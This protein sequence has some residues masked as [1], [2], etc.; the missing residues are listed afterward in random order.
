ML[1]FGVLFSI[2]LIASLALYAGTQAKTQKKMGAGL[3]TGVML[4]TIIGGA[5]TVGTAQLAFTYG[6]CAWWFTIGCGIATLILAFIFVGPF[7][8]GNGKT[9]IG[10]I[11]SEYGQHVGVTASVL[12]S[13]G[14][15]INV[16]S[17]LIAATSVIAVV[18]PQ[19]N[20]TVSLI[21]SALLMI[22]YVVF[23]G[24]RGAGIVGLLK[25]T[26][27]C[28]SMLSCG[29]I[30]LYLCDGL[31]GFISM[32]KTIETP[33]GEQYL[34][35]F[36]RGLSTDLGA[37]FSLLVGI[38]TTQ[39]YCQAITTADSNQSARRGIILSSLLIPIIGAGGVLVGLYMRAHYPE[40]LAKTALTQF[41]SLHMPD[42][43]GGIVLGTLFIAV[44]GSGACLS[45]G[46]ATIL[47]KDLMGPKLQKLLKI[48]SSN[49]SMQV[50]LVAVLGT[51][52]LC[53]VVLESDMILNFAFL[54]MAL[55]GSVVL[56][57][58]LGALW[59]KGKIS[60]CY[61]LAASI[62]GPS[63]M[64]GLK[65]YGFQWVDPLFIA[66]MGTF[67]LM[68]IGYIRQKKTEKSLR[69]C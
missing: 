45:L 20:L 31:G 42:L 3:V 30:V 44:V 49:T 39:I 8:K 22:I 51:A 17:Q 33:N 21:G 65:L 15:F 69:N 52:A 25:M 5:S 47:Q 48:K 6:V 68:A 56:A 14:T 26:L 34:N 61:A 41:V 66:I 63:I 50:I 59:F 2:C 60:G 55:R 32:V 38:V 57:P 35:F 11:S 36:A 7:R 37:C 43:L 46:I 18:W 27:M 16:L 58:L 28:V 62:L 4:G 9:L 64:I 29:A 12:N 19:L 54:S 40:I 24:T 53:C 67:L 10:M 1:I 13:F 23:G